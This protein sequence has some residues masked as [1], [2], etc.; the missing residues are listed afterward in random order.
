MNGRDFCVDVVCRT[1]SGKYFLIEMQNDSTTGYADKSYVEFARFLA[2]ID[3]NMIDDSSL[4]KD[5]KRLR[6]GGKH[7]AAKDFWTK[8]GEICTIVISN[9]KYSPEARKEKYPDETAAEP[10]VI[11]TYEM[12]HV[13]HSKR[14]L[15]KLDA[16]I[17]LVM[18]ANFN[19]TEDQLESVTD[20]WLFALKD[21][22]MATGMVKI[23]PFKEVSDIGRV[24]AGCE[25]LRQF[26]AELHPRNIGS[27]RLREYERRLQMV[28]DTLDQN[29]SEGMEQGMERGVELEKRATILKMRSMGMQDSVI[30]QA[31]RISEQKLQELTCMPEESLSA[32]I[33]QKG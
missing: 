7:V 13:A 10:D 6:V 28:N 1:E 3:G 18:L 17:V 12:R 15:G 29:F 25:A 11:N 14:H 23:D 19:K 5:R 31:L 32:A 26:Y 22:R 33:I 2:G 30:A 24:A 21:E 20:R 16:K 4:E 9:K 27:G 8:I